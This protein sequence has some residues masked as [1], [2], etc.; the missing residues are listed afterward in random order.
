VGEAKR[1]RYEAWLSA[2]RI[3]G[4]K[5]LQ[6]PAEQQND[7]G[8]P[9]NG[10][11]T[12]GQTP[13]ARARLSDETTYVTTAFTALH[14][15]DFDPQRDQEIEDRF[16]PAVRERMCRDRSLLIRRVFGTYPWQLEPNERRVLNLY[17]LYDTWLAEGRV[18]LLPLYLVWMGAASLVRLARFVVRAVREIR[19]PEL[20]VDRTAEVDADFA[21]AVRKLR[22]MRGPVVEA[23]LRLRT[24]LDPEY[25]GVPLP[26]GERT[27]LEGADVQSDLKF[28]DA[29]PWLVE[30]VEHERRRAEADM[31]RLGR[32]IEG[33]L[34]ERIAAR[35]RLDPAALATPQHRRA[36]AVAYLADFR[37]VRRRLSALEIIEE[38]F[39]GESPEQPPPPALR[40]RPGLRRLFHRYWLARDNSAYLDCRFCWQCVVHNIWGVADALCA[41][42]RFGD[43]AAAEGEQILAEVLRHPGRITEQLVTLRTVQTLSI[44]DVLNYRQHILQLGDYAS[45]GDVPSELLN[46]E[47]FG[48][49]A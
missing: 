26:G 16:G 31:R 20:R 6:F 3:A 48:S 35:L 40:P 42:H 38:V 24:M 19:R 25:S 46:W 49:P 28:L 18:F 41:W 27:G 23:C 22:R 39:R 44:L 14:F 12:Y 34:I 29:E 32:L 8:A 36:A 2:V 4:S 13:E 1:Q 5:A 10:P 21:T 7:R 33:G 9:H 17:T 45:A 43:K 15:L 47:T 11:Q 30:R 37:G